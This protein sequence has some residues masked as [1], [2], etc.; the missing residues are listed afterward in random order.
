MACGST[1]KFSHPREYRIVGVAGRGA[2][3]A[4]CKA[5]VLDESLAQALGLLPEQSLS[6]QATT[7]SGQYSSDIVH[8]APATTGSSSDN[9][10]CNSLSEANF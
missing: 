5:E 4:V 8:D 9:A 7:L 10:L 3:A 2:Y 1:F 6:R